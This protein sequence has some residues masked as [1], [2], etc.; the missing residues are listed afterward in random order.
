MGIK[1]RLRRPDVGSIKALKELSLISAGIAAGIA[2][3]QSVR[4]HEVSVL[5]LLAGLLIAMADGFG[6]FLRPRRN[7]SGQ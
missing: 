2:I 7:P 3:D 5:F 6:S 4:D 1:E